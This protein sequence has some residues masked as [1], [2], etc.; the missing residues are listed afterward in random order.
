MELNFESR[1]TFIL[2]GKPE[3]LA[4]RASDYVH[5]ELLTVDGGLMG[6]NLG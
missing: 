2:P 6:V 5:G 3:D 4:Y 1:H